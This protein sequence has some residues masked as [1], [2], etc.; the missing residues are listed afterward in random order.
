[1]AIDIPRTSRIFIILEP[2]I[3]PITKL[4]SFF[5]IAVI[6]VTSS[7]RLVPRAT[8]D[9]DITITGIPTGLKFFYKILVVIFFDNLKFGVVK[10]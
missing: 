3:F 9:K 10:F 7:G 1:M 5:L 4:G 8:T 2:I 6:D